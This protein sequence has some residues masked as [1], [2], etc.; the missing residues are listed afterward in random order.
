MFI[1]NEGFTF[2][3]MLAAPVWVGHLTPLPIN[4]HLCTEAYF[5]PKA[6]L[7]TQKKTLLFHHPRPNTEASV[8]MCVKWSL[9][10]KLFLKFLKKKSNEIWKKCNY[11]VYIYLENC[12]TKLHVWCRPILCH[13]NFTSLLYDAYYSKKEGFNQITKD[14][15]VFRDLIVFWMAL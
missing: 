14:I 2:L 6:E 3:K 15:M 11:F 8:S 12:S 5:A 9:G 13:I 10:K 1:C 4:V 7:Q